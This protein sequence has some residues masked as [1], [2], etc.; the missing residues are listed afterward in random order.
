MTSL[1]TNHDHCGGFNLGAGWEWIHRLSV[2][3]LK[4]YIDFIHF[5]TCPRCS[6]RSERIAA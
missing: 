1:C 3:K 2:Q 6:G 5:T 4:K